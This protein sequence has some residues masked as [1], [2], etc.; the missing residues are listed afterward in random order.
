MGAHMDED[1]QFSRTGM[2]SPMG[3]LTE[4]AKTLIDFNTMQ[5]FRELVAGCDMDVAG[6][7][8]DWIYLQVH[9]Q[10]YTDICVHASK[11]KARKLFGEDPNAARMRPDSPAAPAAQQKQPE[12]TA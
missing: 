12:V 4:P 1:V 8:R 11:I 3:T 2:V 10:T 9:G 6:A 5:A 7:I